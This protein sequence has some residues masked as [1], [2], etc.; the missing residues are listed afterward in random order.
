MPDFA[1]IAQRGR[2]ETFKTKV[3]G[4]LVYKARQVY[5]AGVEA[6]G[7]ASH[8]FAIGVLREVGQYEGTASWGW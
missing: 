2:D 5:V 7:E 4:A 6:A 3:R 8:S 1:L